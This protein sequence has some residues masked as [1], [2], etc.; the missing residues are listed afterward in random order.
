[1]P[2]QAPNATKEEQEGTWVHLCLELHRMFCSCRDAS[3]HLQ[4][5]LRRLAEAGSR[6]PLEGTSSAAAPTWPSGGADATTA[7]TTGAPG[8]DGGD[9]EGAADGWDDALLAELFTEAAEDA[10]R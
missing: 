7:L 9:A 6:G 8:D 2:W 1:M 5:L 4:L 10:E 3:G